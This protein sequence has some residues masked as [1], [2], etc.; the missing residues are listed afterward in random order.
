MENTTTRNDSTINQSCSTIEPWSFQN[1]KPLYDK[2]VLGGHSTLVD[3]TRAAFTSVQEN[4]EGNLEVRKTFE[5]GLVSITRV[6]LTS[7]QE[8]RRGRPDAARTTV[9]VFGI[10]SRVRNHIKS[11]KK[12]QK[13]NIK[14]TIVR[15]HEQIT[16]GVQN[17][18]GIDTKTHQKKYV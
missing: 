3:F 13:K 2:L 12:Y 14:K 17:E 1:P 8:N 5:I 11:I 9:D 6:R 15:K 4:V 16:K 18:T 10:H 7:V